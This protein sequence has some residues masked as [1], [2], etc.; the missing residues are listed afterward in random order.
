MHGKVINDVDIMV[1]FAHCVDDNTLVIIQVSLVLY[2][3]NCTCTQECVIVKFHHITNIHDQ[4]M[5]MNTIQQSFLSCLPAFYALA[6]PMSC[7]ICNVFITCVCVCVL[8]KRTKQPTD[9]L[10]E[11]V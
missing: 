1:L 9:K 4:F 6:I 10:T 11:I 5:G 7:Y 8:Y 2:L 3:R